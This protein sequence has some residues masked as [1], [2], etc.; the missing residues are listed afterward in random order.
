MRLAPSVPSHLG[1]RGLI[2]P[3]SRFIRRSLRAPCL[4]V[5]GF[6][7]AINKPSMGGHYPHSIFFD[8]TVRELVCL[9]DAFYG[10]DYIN[11]TNPLAS[12]R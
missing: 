3:D 10:R 11:V 5:F 4:S 1:I 9:P 7:T 8:D 12:G 2:K 6:E